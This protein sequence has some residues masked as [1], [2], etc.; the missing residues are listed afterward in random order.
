MHM[1]NDPRL[2][3]RDR[4]GNGATIDTTL[5]EV[6]A[7]PDH[8]GDAIAFRHGPIWRNR[9]ALAPLT[10]MQSDHDGTI[11]EDEL[12]FL[13]MRAMGG[14]GLVM[15]CAATIQ[16]SGT[17]FLGQLSISD[18]LHVAGLSRLAAA[19]RAQGA[20]SAVQLQHAGARAVPEISGEPAVSPYADDGRGVRALTTAEVERLVHDYVAAAVRAERAG[21][22]GAELHGAHGYMLCQFLHSKRNKRADGYGGTYEGRTR[23]F[24]E[25]IAG[26]RTATSDA[27]QLGVRL[28]S[29]R[30]G[31]SLDEAVR[32]AGEL[33]ADERVD[34]VDMSLWDCFKSPYEPAGHERRL[35]DIFG[36][37]P[38][39][40][41]ARLGVAGNILS[42]DDALEC[43]RAG[44]DFIFFG[45]GAI[46]HHDIARCAIDNPD[47]V[48]RRLP[49][50]RAY[51]AD[52]GIGP[53]FQDYLIKDWPE[54]FLD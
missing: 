3:Q 7:S 12:H 1:N 6:S 26:I 37:L 11:G 45:R 31:Y 36:G 21:L 46:V 16:R 38:R 25:I 52:Q 44:A 5:S 30:Y 13:Q 47:F 50:T 39:H 42:S 49:V 33:L 40:S 51:L 35:I 28:S 20:V 32:F 14:F 24:R 19:L 43:L 17:S 22:D 10:N 18:D 53:R 29:E 9:T 15:T 4:R 41:A 34:Y 8:L 23:I 54:D 2:G 48:A 27:F